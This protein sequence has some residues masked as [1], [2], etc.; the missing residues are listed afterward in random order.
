MRDAR[1]E[2]RVVLTQGRPLPRVSAI[3]TSRS[4]D[5]RVYLGFLMSWIARAVPSDLAQEEG[6]RR[7]DRSRRLHMYCLAWAV[8]TQSSVAL[9]SS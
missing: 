7:V 5:G 1:C 6:V 3:E 2:T 9:P 4:W 8:S